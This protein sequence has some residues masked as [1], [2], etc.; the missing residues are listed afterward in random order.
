MLNKGQTHLYRG[1]AYDGK[2][3]VHTI[4]MAGRFAA[5]YWIRDNTPADALVITPINV[6]PFTNV[7]PERQFYVKK[8]QYRICSQTIYPL[9]TSAWKRFRVSTV[10]IRLPINTRCYWQRCL[11]TCPDR[12]FYAVVRDAEIS[13]Q[14]MAE[15]GAKLVFEDGA[16]GANVYWLNPASGD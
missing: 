5:Y 6:I 11:K 7:L 10:T 2:H 3:I 9:M 1:F 15:R 13:P 16:D 12:P 4:D 14:V 8:A